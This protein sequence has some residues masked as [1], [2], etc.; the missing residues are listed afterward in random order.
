VAYTEPEVAWVGLTETRAKE[1]GTAYEVAS[2]PWSASGRALAIGGTGGLTKLLFDP[3]THRVLGGGIV[4]PNAGELIAEITFALEM[5]ADVGDLALT[6][7]PHPTLSETVTFAAELA[8]GVITDLPNPEAKKP[9][10]A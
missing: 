1:D 6:V 2:F 3:E 4:G 5:G 7:H 8:D 9:A 10:K